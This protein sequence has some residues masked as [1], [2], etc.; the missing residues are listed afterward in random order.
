MTLVALAPL[1][2]AVEGDSATH[3]ADIRMGL[4]FGPLPKKND[5]TITSF[6]SAP[7]FVGT[8]DSTT[9]ESSPGLAVTLGGVVG[10]L[11]PV[12]LLLGGEL[13]YLNGEQQVSEMTDENGLRTRREIA[14]AAGDSVPDMSYSQ[15]GI[16]GL[17][18]VG[19]AFSR[20]VHLEVLALA[21]LDWVTADLLANRLGPNLQI[22]EGT[23][24]GYTLGGR[25]GAYWTDAETSWQFGLEAE[26]LRTRSELNTSYIDATTE[27]T[28][29]NRGISVRAVI[30]HRF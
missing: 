13:R 11:D 16:A 19:F 26:W 30:G 10:S 18:G 5:G 14:A 2:G 17:A 27:S 15:F 1:A 24:P 4:G 28:V 29:V 9:F 20:S 25:V 7:G 6:P 21:G 8:E 3:V 23:G 22:Q 12:G